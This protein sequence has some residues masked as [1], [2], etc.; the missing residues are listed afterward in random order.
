[1]RFLLHPRQKR[2][3]CITLQEL[4]VHICGAR[5]VVGIDEYVPSKT[6]IHSQRLLLLKFSVSVLLSTLTEAGEWGERQ[7]HHGFV[8]S[9]YGFD[10]YY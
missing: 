1:M 9:S 3:G 2:R 10:K 7:N 4:H 5:E 8:F 6:G